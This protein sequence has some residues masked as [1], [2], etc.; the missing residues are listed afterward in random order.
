MEDVST[1]DEVE[2]SD[3]LWKTLRG[4]NHLVF[5]NARRTVETYADLLGRKSDSE[6]VPNEFFPH[7]GSLSKELREV[8]EERL[9]KG[10]LPTTVIC[11]ST[12]ELGIDI[13]AV[14]SVA[15]IGP[16]PS[17]ASLRQRLGR[18]GRRGE[19][20]IL[21]STSPRNR[22][23]PARLRR[24]RSGPLPCPGGRDGEPPPREGKVV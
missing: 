4:K 5:A 11:T 16:P 19:P 2:I 12:L 10:T 24:I 17:V 1:G 9:K 6:N 22:S 20:S 18:S 14:V 3:A 23:G 21:R 15:Q 13:G 8:C 7:H